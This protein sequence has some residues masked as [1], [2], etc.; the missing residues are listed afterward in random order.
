MKAFLFSL[1]LLMNVSFTPPG[2]V[3]I[4]VSKSSKV[5]H[6]NKNCRGIKNCTHEIREVTVSDAKN[7][8]G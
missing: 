5:Y 3:F 8:Y 1:V 6:S 4:C 2:N 7:V